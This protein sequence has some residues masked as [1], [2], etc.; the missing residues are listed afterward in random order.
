[1]PHQYFIDTLNIDKIKPSL[2]NKLK[3]KFKFK[4]IKEEILFSNNGYYK[5]KDNDIFLYKI[6][7]NNSKKIPN[8]FKEISLYKNEL[9]IKKISDISQLPVNFIKINIKKI[10]FSL[11]NNET[12]MIFEFN[13]D[14]II[15]VY[16][17]SK[18]KDEKDYFFLND[19][20]LYLESLN[21]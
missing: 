18:N 6:F 7:C 14:K 9:Y 16:F 8:F 12:N 17:T 5:I 11:S 19:I 2:I 15:K 13:H 4:E 21:I 3:D 10:Y 20:S 1:M